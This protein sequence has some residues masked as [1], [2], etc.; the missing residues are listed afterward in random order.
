MQKADRR[1]AAVILVLML[2]VLAVIAVAVAR[3]SAGSGPGQ[4]LKPARDGAAV[5]VVPRYNGTGNGGLAVV[6]PSFEEG[7]TASARVETIEGVAFTLN[8]GPSGTKLLRR[9]P[10]I[11]AGVPADI[12]EDVLAQGPLPVAVFMKEGETVFMAGDHTGTF[13]VTVR[14]ITALQAMCPVGYCPPGGVSRMSDDFMRVG[15]EPGQWEVLAG[16]WELTALSH[17]DRSTNPFVL[18]FRPPGRR[19]DDP[20]FAERIGLSRIG[21]GAMIGGIRGMQTVSRLSGNG[22]ASRSGVHEDDIVLSIDSGGGRSLFGTYDDKVRLRILRPSTGKTVN[23]TIPRE[24][25]RWGETAVPVPWTGGRMEPVG[26]LTT[27]RSDWVSGRLEVSVSLDRFG[28]G[29]LVFNYQDSNN[30]TAAVLN[31]GGCAAIVKNSMGRSTELARAPAVVWPGSF[32]RM[33]V[34]FGG[35]RAVMDLDGRE[36]LSTDLPDSFGRAGIFAQ[37][38]NAVPDLPARPPMFDDFEYSAEPADLAGSGGASSPEGALISAESSV[39]DWANPAGRWL[40]AGDGRY[41]FRYAVYEEA[42]LLLARL[43]E[44]TE[45]AVADETGGPQS[46]GTF[47]WTA[48]PAAT[49]ARITIGAKNVSVLPAG[50]AGVAESAA[51]PQNPWRRVFIRMASGKNP[52]GIANVIDDG[53]FDESFDRAPSSLVFTGGFWG[54]ANK[55]VCDPRFSFLSTRSGETA[56]AWWKGIVDGDFTIDYYVSTFMEMLDEPFERSGDYNLSITP[57]PGDLGAGYTLSVGEDYDRVSRFYR[58]GAVLAETADPDLQPPANHLYLPFRQDFHRH[59]THVRLSRRG[60]AFT[61]ELDGRT[62]FTVTDPDAI[63][64][65]VHVAVWTQR[66]SLLFGRLL[67]TG[68]LRQGADVPVRFPAAPAGYDDGIY[69]NLWAGVPSASVRAAGDGLFV[70]QPVSGPFVIARKKPFY[71][72]AGQDMVVNIRAKPASGSPVLGAYV[73]PADAAGFAWGDSYGDGPFVDSWPEKGPPPWQSYRPRLYDKG[74]I[75]FIPL[76]GDLPQELPFVPLQVASREVEEDGT[77]SV[78]AIIR[79]PENIV[80]GEKS[81]LYLIAVGCLHRTGYRASALTVNPP[82]TS[83]LLL[84]MSVEPAPEQ[85]VQ[86]RGNPYI[87]AGILIIPG[88]AGPVTVSIGTV[89]PGNTLTLMPC[90]PFRHGEQRYRLSD[91]GREVAEGTPLHLR[92]MTHDQGAV[93]HELAFADSPAA[94]P[95][96]VISISI[97]GRKADAIDFSDENSLAGRYG[98]SALLVHHP[99]ESG[100]T[101]IAAAHW[102]AMSRVGLFGG[103]ARPSDCFLKL[104]Y[105][106]DRRVSLSPHFESAAASIVWGDGLDRNTEWALHSRFM[107]PVPDVPFDGDGEWHTALFNLPLTLKASGMPSA[108]YRPSALALAEIGWNGMMLGMGLDLKSAELL[109]L[110]SAAAPRVDFTIRGVGD[111]SDWRMYV[112]DG[113]SVALTAVDTGPFPLRTAVL[114]ASGVERVQL[115]S[116]EDG[117]R[118]VTVSVADS[119]GRWSAPVRRGFVLDRTPPTVIFVPEKPANLP[120]LSLL[121]GHFVVTDNLSGVDL[122]GVS[123]SICDADGRNLGSYRSGNGLRY[124]ADTGVLRVVRSS[125]PDW[126]A[127][128]SVTMTLGGIA[129]I[130]GNSTP[131]YGPIQLSVSGR[132]TLDGKVLREGCPETGTG[133]RTGMHAPVV[134]YE[135]TGSVRGPLPGGISAM[136]GGAQYFTESAGS[137]RP[138]YNVRVTQ[139]D[140]AGIGGSGGGLLRTGTGEWRA[141]LMTRYMDVGR[142]EY[143]AFSYNADS[144]I[145]SLSVE[146]HIVGGAV[147]RY[148]LPLARS[149]WTTVLLDLNGVYEGTGIKLASGNM[150]IITR[151]DIVGFT[152][153]PLDASWPAGTVR[154]DAYGAARKPVLRIHNFPGEERALLY[155][156]HGGD[157]PLPCKTGRMNIAPAGPG[158]Q[159]RIFA[160]PPGLP[161]PPGAAAVGRFPAVTIPAGV[162]RVSP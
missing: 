109:P 15:D 33:G 104:Q 161:E 88:A 4:A 86:E 74:L 137:L 65:P 100:F 46:D 155:R 20:V 98:V 117:I 25:Y 10:D 82:G 131:D 93:E 60:S 22:P 157:P 54:I 1:I 68:R 19:W 133:T 12:V 124:D 139:Q 130:A 140:G 91:L 31:G 78:R 3:W 70:T 84:D 63:E 108:G 66:N 114:D 110:V 81:G 17:P 129:D 89:A 49:P 14:K 50:S 146:A 13:P 43:D 80:G 125:L 62:G 5:A 112:D 90:E 107:S 61:Y 149:S 34:V 126:A 144:S 18:A 153:G 119:T 87:V 92:W 97:N 77:V 32:Y 96:E 26:I 132:I 48:T 116:L 141:T 64:G 142:E 72:Y 160:V 36:I 7:V 118:Y 136:L 134:F 162:I 39:R 138:H 151:L 94:A 121:A 145:T 152:E 8:L 51:A 105:R 11:A 55:W 147:R 79:H 102:G 143:F 37:V 83:Y 21:I 42:T 113:E 16:K 59:W 67:I 99:E 75:G 76:F 28:A 29:G 123:L 135:P 71:A 44:T 52:S 53:A 154:L 73:L 47:R 27:G 150:R 45:I 159:I 106:A 2:F 30:Y 40:Y 120:P 115:D 103:A 23:F 122:S 128:P 35:G 24:K 38:D 58:K 41:V 9:A 156:Q 158:E 69:T 101:R 148:D 56:A 127:L 85:D 57:V 95:P 6:H 111:V